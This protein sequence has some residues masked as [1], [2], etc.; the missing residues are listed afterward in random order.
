MTLIIYFLTYL[1]ET[2]Q[3]SQYLNSLP[4]ML[5]LINGEGH[6]NIFAPDDRLVNGQV[7]EITIKY[8]NFIVYNEISVSYYRIGF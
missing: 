6:V 7:R 1:P 3:P 4:I 2:K 5:P 8:I